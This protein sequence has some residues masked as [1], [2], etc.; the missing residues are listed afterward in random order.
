MESEFQSC[1]LA[2]VYDFA[3]GLSKSRSE[4]GAGHPFLG[5]KDVFYNSAVPKDLKELVRSTD[6]ER[7]K[8]SVRRGD[9][10]LT[11]TS[12]TM[13]ELG[14]SCVALRDIPFATFN[15]FT[16][17]LRPRSE[18]VIAP[19][20]ARYYFRSNL[21]RANVNSM[22]TMSTRASLNNEMLSRLRIS[23]PNIYEQ[24]A[25]GEILGTLDDKIELNRKTNE[26][27]EGIAKALFKS[28]FVDFDPVRAKAEGR[29]TG[30][31]DEISELFPDSFEESELGEIPKNW[32]PKTFGDFTTAR[33][34][35]MIT[36]KDTVEGRIPVVAGGMTPAYFHNL[37]NVDG[38]VVTISASGA[39]AGFVNLYF[40]S[41]WASDCSYISKTESEFPFT[42]YLFL[43]ASQSRI[44]DAQHGGVQPHINPGD[45]GRLDFA[46]A[47]K[48]VFKRF[49]EIIAPI[50]FKIESAIKESR[51]LECLRDALLP[52]LISGELR[53]P[54]AEKMLEEAG[55]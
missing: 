19:E 22:S 35:R 29:P 42:C 21:F 8:C 10:F 4:F 50:F 6:R 36:R 49:E 17:R 41:I 30:L 12:E 2:D 5:F 45:I 38:P 18:D 26:T 23:F 44:Y 24:Q 43:K 47:E 39:N 28:W 46:V 55:V 14:M 15:G 25:I 32:K 27:L 34:G 16:K 13:N 51:H 31:P 1:S 7:E 9:V 33:R 52:R 40:D 53:V 37:S 3:S 20:Y 54:D 11:R 48:Q